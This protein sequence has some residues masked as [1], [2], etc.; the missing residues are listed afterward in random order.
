VSM[1][2]RGEVLLKLLPVRSQAMD[3][4]T[5]WERLKA[6]GVTASLRTVQ[7]DLDRLAEDY[8][9]IQK[10]RTANGYRW[11]AD[12]ALSRLSLLPADAMNLTMILDHAARFG[13][14]AQVEKLALLRDY[15]R[16]LLKDTH[17][18]ADWTKKISSTTRFVMLR[19][20]RID[21]EVLR[22]LQ[23]AL[24]D[25]FAV[26]ASY[27]KR[28]AQ[29]P[30]TYR[31]KPLGLS[32]QDSNIYLSCVF[33]G[34]RPGAP[35]RALPLHRF[36]SARTIVDVLG[37]PED[38]DINAVSA[39]RSLVDLQS[40]RPVE[41]VLLLGKDMYQRLVENP[42]VEGQR[43]QPEA[44]GRWLLAAHL[45]LS[46]GLKLWLLSQGDTLEVIRPMQLRDE[47]AATAARMAALY[48]VPQKTTA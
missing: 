11:W 48:E 1:R 35:V 9:H 13:M 31:L 12:R 41:L 37:A 16:A 21:P 7:R 20:S 34:Y 8:P 18:S 29:E 33:E 47:I 38:F 28:G 24:L 5:I 39:R 40:D 6:Q 36:V 42:L 10:E 14:Q 15:A 44:D 23:H 26:E 27:L 25:D 30:R 22:T 4:A 2:K 17:P 46:Q 3:T 43:L 19:P 45:H 32:F